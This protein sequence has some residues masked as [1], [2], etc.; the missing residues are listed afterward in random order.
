MD[1]LDFLGFSQ[2]MPSSDDL[3][4]IEKKLDL[5]MSRLGLEYQPLTEQVRR[6]ADNGKKIEAIRLYRE[7]TGLG[8]VDA[9]EDVEAYMRG[10]RA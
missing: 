10:S 7:E 8:L 9:K 5:I 2:R 1:I 3:R 4:R 6:A